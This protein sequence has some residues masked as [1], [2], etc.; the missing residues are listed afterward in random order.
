M[1]EPCCPCGETGLCSMSRPGLQSL[2]CTWGCTSWQ[3]L[4]LG[5]LLGG[6][7]QTGLPRRGL[8]RTPRG[9]CVHMCSA[10]RVK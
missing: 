3:P 4:L 5:A 8:G 2:L 6:Q 9:G 1:R 10:L 7:V